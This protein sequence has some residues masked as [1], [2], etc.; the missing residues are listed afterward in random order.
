VLATWH[1]LLDSGRMQDGEPNLAGTA[2]RPVARDVGV[3][4]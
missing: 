1:N 4:G 3:D 2:R